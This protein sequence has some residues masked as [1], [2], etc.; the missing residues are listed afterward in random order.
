MMV[1]IKLIFV[2][3]PKR[4][5]KDGKISKYKFLKL[6]SYNNLKYCSLKIQIIRHLYFLL[7][8]CKKLSLI[9]SKS[10]ISAASINCS[11]KNAF[12]IREV[13]FQIEKRQDCA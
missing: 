5:T 7:K 1:A 12:S 11:K 2:C 3:M 13:F 10:L 8:S 4:A 6:Q 9:L